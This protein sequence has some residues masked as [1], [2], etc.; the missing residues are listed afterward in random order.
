MFQ[1]IRNV[2][3]L[4]K[5]NY[6]SKVLNSFGRFNITINNLKELFI[7]KYLH[8]SIRLIYIAGVIAYF[9]GPITS[10]EIRE[11]RSFYTHLADRMQ[12]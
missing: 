3:F 2:Q 5:K 1:I 4:T 10:H 11:K 12:R 7:L 9:L 6:L 8:F